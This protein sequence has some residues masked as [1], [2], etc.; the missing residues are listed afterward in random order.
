[1]TRIHKL[2]SIRFWA[3]FG[4]LLFATMLTNPDAAMATTV[5]SQNLAQLSETAGSA[6]VVRIDDVQATTTEKGSCDIVSGVVTEPVFGDVQTSQS[7]SWKQF[8]LGRGVGLPG[9]P[10]YEP[11]TEYLVFLSGKAT[12]TGFQAPMGLGQGA[13]V[14]RR[15]PKTG[16]AL[17]RNAFGNSTLATG[18]DVDAVASDMAAGEGKSR[19][20]SSRQIDA[21]KA[22]LRMQL[23]GRSMGNSLDA[24]KQAAQFFHGKKKSGELPSEDYRTSAPVRPFR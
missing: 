1:M 22:R 17:V 5:V 12:S 24:L 16:A 14:V 18:L 10:K 9:M 15:D 21:E 8:R 19:G 20:L 3:V 2:W 11:R 13:F 23:K 7:I 4:V 6:F